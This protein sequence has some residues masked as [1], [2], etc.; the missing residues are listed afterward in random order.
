MLGLRA[1]P[2]PQPFKHRQSRAGHPSIELP[3][4]VVAGPALDSAVLLRPF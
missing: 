1:W 2:P 4:A 3:F